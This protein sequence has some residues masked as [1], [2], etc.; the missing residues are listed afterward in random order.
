MA[1][2]TSESETSETP[3]QGGAVHTWRASRARFSAPLLAILCDANAKETVEFA[4]DPHGGGDPCRRGLL[5]CA[6]GD[7]PDVT[8]TFATGSKSKIAKHVV[9]RREEAFRCSVAGFESVLFEALS[10]LTLNNP[11]TATT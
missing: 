3:C 1:A 2:L 11:L 10:Y 8:Q 4:C 5:S 9:D 7:G 6:R